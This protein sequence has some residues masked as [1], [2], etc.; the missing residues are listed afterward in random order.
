MRSTPPDTVTFS[1]SML[2]SWVNVP[3]LALLLPSW[4]LHRVVSSAV[5]S[6]SSRKSSVGRDAGQDKDAVVGVVARRD[7]YRLTVVPS[8]IMYVREASR[9]N[10]IASC[11]LRTGT[12]QW[13]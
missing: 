3:P 8:V 2:V 13:S 5:P 10:A 1:R 4:A 12:A 11:P 6:K 7:S 9:E